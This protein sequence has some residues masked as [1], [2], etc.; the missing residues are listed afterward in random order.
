LLTNTMCPGPWS[1]GYSCAVA[2]NIPMTDLPLNYL[3]P[4]DQLT[5]GNTL[6]YFE[7]TPVQYG[8]MGAV[9]S[10][11]QT[12][13]VGAVGTALLTQLICLREPDDFSS[14][15][16]ACAPTGGG[17]G[18]PSSGAPL[19]NELHRRKRIRP[20]GTPPQ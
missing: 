16:G 6:L 3:P 13:W 17:P 4:G 9:L 12:F 11:P 19:I 5:T 10:A 15:Y 1:A 8:E 14:S 7:L 2:V 20:I 18:S